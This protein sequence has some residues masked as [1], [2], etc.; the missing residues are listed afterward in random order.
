M[1]INR[2]KRSCLKL[3]AE[4]DGSSTNHMVLCVYNLNFTGIMLF[5][6]LETFVELS[7]TDGWYV[8]PAE[9]DGELERLCREKKIYIGQK[10]HIQGALV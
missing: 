3:I 10:L 1:E 5:D 6:W 2:A 9:I 4:K 8:L 7:L